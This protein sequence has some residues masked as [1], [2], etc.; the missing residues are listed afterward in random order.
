MIP[1]GVVRRDP[2]WDP[3]RAKTGC[4][5]IPSGVVERNP[6]REKRDPAEYWY[7]GNARNKRQLSNAFSLTGGR[8]PGWSPETW[9]DPGLRDRWVRFLFSL[10]HYSSPCTEIVGRKCTYASR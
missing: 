5:I 1:D 10:F 6:G 4:C 3:G 7:L 2:G 9:N 8:D